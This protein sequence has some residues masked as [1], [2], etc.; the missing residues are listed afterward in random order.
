MTTRVQA[1]R[2]L[3][4]NH[5]PMSPTFEIKRLIA[6]IYRNF[7]VPPPS[8]RLTWTVDSLFEC[9]LP[10]NQRLPPLEL[11]SDQL[12]LL[13]LRLFLPQSSLKPKR[14]PRNRLRRP[15]Q[16]ARCAMEVASQIQR[17]WHLRSAELLVRS[18]SR[19]ERTIWVGEV[20][21]RRKQVELE[22]V[23]ILPLYISTRKT[24]ARWTE[25]EASQARQEG[26]P[27]LFRIRPQ[28]LGIILQ[29]ASRKSWK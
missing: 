23:P 5:S 26:Y 8:S 29:S 15:Y 3:Q 12:D 27:P 24:V 22:P 4:V 20:A 9:L 6:I 14:P 1:E 11:P 28:D 13:H 10:L 21:E 2:H 18:I 19:T 25:V 16:P 7:V 17:I